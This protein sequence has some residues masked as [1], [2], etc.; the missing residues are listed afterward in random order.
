MDPDRPR[1]RDQG[2]GWVMVAFGSLTFAQA[3]LGMLDLPGW[4]H[5]L[6]GTG[7]SGLVCWITWLRDRRAAARRR[8]ETL[9]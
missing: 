2:A 7:V 9:R 3:Q 1:L 5:Y 6:V 8:R 4:A